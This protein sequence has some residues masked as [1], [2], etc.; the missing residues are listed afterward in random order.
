MTAAP[1]TEAA[2]TSSKWL[3]ARLLMTALVMTS[4]FL[5]I[6]GK[7]W[8]VQIRDHKRMQALG[9][10][11][12][13]HEL[14]LPAP[15]GPILDTNGV[16]LAVSVEVQSLFANPR[17]V[18]DPAG[19]A[20]ALA[21]A[22]GLDI[23]DQLDLETKLGSGKRFIWIKRRL[24][25]VETVAVRQLQLPG[26]GLTPEA[27]RY[28][29]GGNLGGPLLGVAGLDGHGLE[30]VELGLDAK[31]AGERAKVPVL[32]D[33]RGAVLLHGW[34]ESDA[35]ATQGATAVL[36]VDR[37]IQF[38]AERAI[39]E[40]VTVNKAKAGV[41]VVLDAATSD[42]LAMASYPTFDPNE[43]GKHDGARNRPITD[44]YEPG[45]TMKIFS[46]S[47]ALDAGAVK[48]DDTWN[49][50]GGRILVGGKPVTDVHAKKNI[51]TTSE[52]VKVSSN[53]G[54]TKIAFRLGRDALHAQ[55]L[56]FGFGK[57]TGI[58][59]PGERNGTVRDPKK[60]GDR[61]LASTSFGYG[62]TVTP[63]QIAAGVAAIA[64]GGM[65]LAPHI[66][67]ELRSPDGNV[68]ARP[69]RT[70]HRVLGEVAS[71]QMMKMLETVMEEGGT[72]D[73][74]KVPGFKIAGKT[75]TAHKVDPVTH[76]YAKRYVSS[77]VG[78]VPAQAPRLI[79][80][81][82]IDDPT[83]DQHYGGAVSG[84]VFE[85]LAAESLRYLGIAATEP[86]EPPKGAKGAKSAPDATAKPAAPAPEAAPV[87][88]APPLDSEL[89][90]DDD[91]PP[92]G[93]G[94]AIVVIPDFTGMSVAQA[95]AAARAAGVK[96]ELEGSGR[97][98][99]QFPAAGRAMKSISCRIT[100]D[101]G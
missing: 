58:E 6:L 67:K 38:A 77:F 2:P 23:E 84:P 30:G 36:T 41:V 63:L 40:G 61:G 5:G 3:A 14:E 20:R 88:E 79:I 45:S 75:G 22:L 92:A 43:P 39:A 53:V 32:R 12:Y 13:L 70:P 10:A 47:A 7:A 83:G 78:A 57:Q 93:P 25:P 50:E 101:P 100:F 55:L 37:F 24:S 65:Y 97:A 73:A 69:D 72:G 68:L 82:M 90:A 27:Q 89:D 85:R 4:L 28:Y 80:L 19:S 48:P 34:E 87:D 81:V 62:L 95:V 44:T 52:V 29:P 96:I 9:E 46:V 60:W 59:L 18:V 66:L 8:S 26:I 16:E 21:H 42:V 76:K 64:R 49:I 54:A 99:K 56:R 51:L 71:G 86:I 74:I 91:L 31:L 98:I 94:E 15:R 33:G 11:Q 35:Q 1:G 17:E